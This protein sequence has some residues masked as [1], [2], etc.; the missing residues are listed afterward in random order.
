MPRSKKRWVINPTA[1]LAEVDRSL[2]W[3]ES[4]LQSVSGDQSLKLANKLG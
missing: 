1:H 2:S 3:C 4:F